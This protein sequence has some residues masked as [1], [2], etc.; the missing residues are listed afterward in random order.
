MSLPFLSVTDIVVNLGVAGLAQRHKIASCVGAAL[1]NRK[2]VVNL[3]RRCESS[4]LEAHLTQRMFRHIPI[5]DTFPGSSV[6][7]VDIGGA[8]VLVIFIPLRFLVERTVLTVG[9]VRAA[10]EAARPFWFAWH[11]TSV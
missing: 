4:V 2:D 6:F 7:L 5:P 1:G 9:P 11:K 3:F 10:G 8:F